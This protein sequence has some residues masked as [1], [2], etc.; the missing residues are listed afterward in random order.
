MLEPVVLM[1]SGPL[2]QVRSFSRDTV[3]SIPQARTCSD[4]RSPMGCEDR[5]LYFGFSFLVL[6]RVPIKGFR[7]S[8]DDDSMSL[9]GD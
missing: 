3:K 4:E 1:V 8:H 7:F 6:G 9:E 5:A 2:V